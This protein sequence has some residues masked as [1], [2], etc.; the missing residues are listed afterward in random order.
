[1]Y[2]YCQ[3]LRLSVSSVKTKA[4]VFRKGGFCQEISTFFY[5]RNDTELEMVSS[6]SYL[7]VVSTSGGLF[8]LVHKPLARQSQKAILN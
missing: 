7:G 6:F 8:S 4:I 5:T 3:K 1:M 2:N